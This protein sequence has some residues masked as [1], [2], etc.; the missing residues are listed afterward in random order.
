MFYYI[1]PL[2]FIFFFV[3]SIRSDNWIWK[4]LF[5]LI[6][7]VSIGIFSIQWTGWIF[8]VALMGMF[9]VVYLIASFIFNVDADR[10]QYDNVLQWLIH[11]KEFL[12][13]VAI[14][15]IAFAGLAVLRGVDGVIG[16]FFKRIRTP[17]LAV[18]F[19][20]CRWVPERTYFRCRDAGT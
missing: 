11:N 13:I 10:G 1:A 4:I 15:V 14:G 8:Y 17:E 20:C 12:S 6:S 5:A 9:A 18:S 19:C 7:V 16:I 3:E 2:F